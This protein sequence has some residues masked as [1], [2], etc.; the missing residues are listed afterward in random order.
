MERVELE[1][2]QHTPATT[3]STVNALHSSV[4]DR[5]FYTRGEIDAELRTLQVSALL[6]KEATLDELINAISRVAPA[7]EG[8][9]AEIITEV[10]N[11]CRSL[12]SRLPS[13]KRFKGLQP[14]GGG[15]GATI[16]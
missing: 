9:A 12:K 2:A 10:L 8:T 1:P 5:D 15:V 13:N 16:S 3:H 11:G 4:P 7:D 6:Q 14:Y